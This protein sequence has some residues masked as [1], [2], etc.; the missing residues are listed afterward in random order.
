M[1]NPASLMR[2]TAVVC[3]QQHSN[4][5][6]T[7]SEVD[8]VSFSIL[9]LVISLRRRARISPCFFKLR[10][11][12]AFYTKHIAADDRSYQ[13]Q[14]RPL[15]IGWTVLFVRLVW[16]NLLKIICPARR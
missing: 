2:D 3:S 10:L 15:S 14:I 1:Y 7:S 11:F 5:S 9:F 16:S 6:L 12:R 4:T 8:P 13:S